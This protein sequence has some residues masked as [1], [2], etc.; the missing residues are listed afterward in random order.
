MK[1]LLILAFL[2]SPIFINSQELDEAY[3]ESLPEDVRE[4]VL[5]EMENQKKDKEPV[6]RRPSTMIEKQQALAEI[7]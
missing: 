7:L 3:L 6:Y 1:K 4:D 5:E 2:I